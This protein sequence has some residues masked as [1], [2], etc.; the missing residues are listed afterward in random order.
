VDPLLEQIAAAV[1]A[2]GEQD[3]YQIRVL[4]SRMTP[5]SGWCRR[6]WLAAWM[7]SSLRSGG[8]RIS[9]RTRSG[10]VVGLG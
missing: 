4:L 5:K 1:R 6:Q 10:L 9:V 8:M 2:L 7:P 3:P